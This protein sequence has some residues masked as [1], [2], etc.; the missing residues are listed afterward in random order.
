M[1]S[2]SCGVTIF[3]QYT[4]SC[5]NR[6]F[7]HHVISEASKPGDASM[8]SSTQVKQCKQ[9]VY[10]FWL[11]ERASFWKSTSIICFWGCMLI[12][13]TELSVLIFSSSLAQASKTN[14]FLSCVFF[15]TCHFYFLSGVVRPFL[16][17][18]KI[19]LSRFISPINVPLRMFLLHLTEVGERCSQRLSEL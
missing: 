1:T 3:V 15:F 11:L 19:E 4:I 13:S 6:V 16:Y 7:V 9:T 12:S 18:L 10:W 5:R 2:F 17:P 8:C 14:F